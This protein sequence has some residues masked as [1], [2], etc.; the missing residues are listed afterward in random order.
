[1]RNDDGAP[2]G[3]T[4]SEQGLASLANAYIMNSNSNS[5]GRSDKPILLSK[6][7]SIQLKQ[8]YDK[9]TARNRNG[10]P[11]EALEK[12][13]EEVKLSGKGYSVS[14]N[15][16]SGG[17]RTQETEDFEKYATIDAC[18]TRATEII[19]AGLPTKRKVDIDLKEFDRLMRGETGIT[20]SKSTNGQAPTDVLRERDKAINHALEMHKEKVVSK[21]RTKYK[22]MAKIG[23]FDAET[24][25]IRVENMLRCSFAKYVGHFRIKNNDIIL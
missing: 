24:N 22:R 21:M 5:G 12:V 20:F 18:A 25:R 1:M 7:S 13:K 3:S 4:I 19:G 23:I 17:W 14:F 6:A 2:K 16:P 11:V 10:I 9:S 15:V 8:A